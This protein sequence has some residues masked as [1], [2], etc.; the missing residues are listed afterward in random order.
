MLNLLLLLMIPQLC[1]F[2]ISKVNSKNWC[3][4][5]VFCER[6]NQTL[7][8]FRC[9]RSFCPLN[10]S[11]GRVAKRMR[12]SYLTKMHI[13]RRINEIRQSWCI[14]KL[15][16]TM[17]VDPPPGGSNTQFRCSNMNAVSWHDGLA[18]LGQCVT[19]TCNKQ[20]VN[21]RNENFPNV[22]CN[23]QLHYFM[24]NY[25]F[26]GDSTFNF[27]FLN[28]RIF[29][30]SYCPRNVVR[31]H[32]MNYKEPLIS[33][34]LV[35]AAALILPRVKYVGCGATT[36]HHHFLYYVC[37]LDNGPI[38]DKP[39]LEGKEA[40]GS[41]LAGECSKDMKANLT[42]LGLCGKVKHIFSIATEKNIYKVL[43]L[44]SFLL[45]L[46]INLAI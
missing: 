28:Y 23:S 30:W 5:E 17:Y 14:C 42:I 9:E 20:Y 33:L 11:C 41:L 1:V 45:T 2:D 38:R 40:G 37:F 36:F 16:G 22:T 10:N 24:K 7:V 39:L 35:N 15:G 6:Q 27:S 8:N 4:D 43:L 44:L 19:N 31:K 26:T 18:Q 46:C 34:G 32:W 13:V 25:N 29:R 12:M 21:V 3:K